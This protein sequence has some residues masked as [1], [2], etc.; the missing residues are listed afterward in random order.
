MNLN[1]APLRRIGAIGDVHGE[2]R[3]LEAVLEFLQAQSLDRIICTGD[4]VDGPGDPSRC[5]KLLRQNDVPTVAGNHDRWLLGDQAR[6]LPEA[7]SLDDL[8]VEALAFLRSLPKTRAFETVAGR[9]LLC[10]GLGDNDMARLL[11]DDSGYALQS[12]MALYAL[13]RG[14]E[15]RFVI[16]G[17]THRRTVRS[18]NRE[19][20][21]NLTIINAGT[22]YRAHQPC[23]VVVDFEARH[24][25]FFDVRE[26]GKIAPAEYREF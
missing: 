17:H 1:I 16:N 19:N 2:A 21:E 3:A 14:S 26:D 18:F 8:D 7:H 9:L 22:L 24:A 25:Q 6:D 15:W 11:P 23:F 4:V 10:H 20:G 12:N 13:H 5:C